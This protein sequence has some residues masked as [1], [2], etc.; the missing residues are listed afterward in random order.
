VSDTLLI[1]AAPGELRGALLAEGGRLVELRVERLGQGGHVG[2]IHLG[3]VTRILPE[4]PAALVEIGLDRPAFLSQEDAIDA[5]TQETRAAGIGAWLHAGQAVLVQVMRE[6]Q[7]EK[8]VGVSLR[9]RLKGRFLALTPTRRRISCPRGCG[10]EEQAR[11]ETLLVGHLLADE[12]VAFN[13]AAIG[14]A[15]EPL[16]AELAPL[17]ARWVRLGERARE[18]SP[19]ALIE[20]ENGPLARLLAGFIEDPPGRILIDDR[21]AFAEARTWLARLHPDLA[22]RLVF[23]GGKG[24]L[25]ERHGVGEAASEATASRVALPGAGALVI[26]EIAAM[27]VIDVDG[28]AGVAGRGQ[29]RQAIL[30]VNRAAADAAA[31][32][33]RRR[34][35]AG[36]IVIDFISMPR[37]ADREAVAGVLQDALAEDPAQPHI[38]G[39]TRLGH[40]ELTRRRRHPPLSEILFEP[41]PGGGR[42]KSALTVALEALRAAA[43]QGDETPGR[44][45]TLVL[46]PEV[47]AAFDH[48]AAPARRALEARLAQGVA[49]VAEPLLARD[50]F[51]IRPD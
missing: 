7:G 28:G 44:R 36:A 4:L 42:R 21:A 12:G 6:A 41:A 23:D 46:H 20:E 43:R 50:A 47:A 19:P 17:R 5:A 31:R 27:T 35:L 40:L 2:E 45:L 37:Q 16:L 32:Q 13:A 8:A 30:A 51:D 39:W 1:S 10:A 15:A 22:D 38:L 3:R 11:L 18:A 48:V 25:F 29:S 26:D 34:N 49:I 14:I 24:E 9:L 33:I